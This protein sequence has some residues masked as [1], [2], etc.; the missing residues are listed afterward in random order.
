MHAFISLS[1]AVVVAGK[2]STHKAINSTRLCL[3]LF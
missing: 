1:Y 2:F 3:V